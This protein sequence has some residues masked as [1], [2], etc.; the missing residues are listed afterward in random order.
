[1]PCRVNISRPFNCVKLGWKKLPLAQAAGRHASAWAASFGSI[2]LC[3]EWDCL[4]YVVACVWEIEEEDLMSGD[5]GAGAPV[6][7][8]KWLAEDVVDG[9]DEGVGEVKADDLLGVVLVN[10][11]AGG[12]MEASIGGGV[13]LGGRKGLLV[14]RGCALVRSKWS[15]Q[16]APACKHTHGFAVVDVICQRMCC[17]MTSPLLQAYA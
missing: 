7:V 11:I 1:M 12:L 10:G 3:M 2:Y 14:S 5:G 8:A 13:L 4:R 16:T 17:T 6:R 9:G 15:R